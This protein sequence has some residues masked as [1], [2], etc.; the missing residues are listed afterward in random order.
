MRTEGGLAAAKGRFRRQAILRIDVLEAIPPVA[1]PAKVVH[2][3]HDLVV[4]T[5][6]AS[7]R[8]VNRVVGA[9]DT[10]RIGIVASGATYLDVR[11]AL[12]S[13]GLTEEHLAAQGVRL[14][15]LGMVYPLVTEEIRSFAQGLSEIIV[16]EEKRSFVETAVKEILFGHPDA[17]RV[18]GKLTSEGQPLLRPYADLTPEIIT[19]ALRMRLVDHV[20]LPASL[21]R[22][23]VGAGSTSGRAN[24]VGSRLSC[25]GFGAHRPD[26]D[27]HGA[28]P[29]SGAR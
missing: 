17:P 20:D 19:S 16:V 25:R 7:V 9:T 14:L 28:T 21:A 1:A 24:L 18:S 26:P 12:N 8:A 23:P 5:S 13:M 10:A 11:Q 6:Y 27:R 15:R 22:T 3:V 29:T 2:V 4:T